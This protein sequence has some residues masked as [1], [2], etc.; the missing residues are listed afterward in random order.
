MQLSVRFEVLEGTP[1]VQLAQ[2]VVC[3]MSALFQPLLLSPV[4]SR[5]HFARA[6]VQQQQQL[7]HVCVCVWLALCR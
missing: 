5:T 7:L 4:A 3:T 1:L 6:S 2:I